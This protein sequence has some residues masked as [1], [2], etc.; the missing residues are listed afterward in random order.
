MDSL[1]LS[2]LNQ[3]DDDAWLRVADR[4]ERAVHPVDRAALRIWLHMYPLALHRAMA[5]ADDPAALA[6]R[7]VLKG[8]WRLA[9]QIDT[10]HRFFY[11]HRYWPEVRQAAIAYV[12]RGSA[13][14]SL[15]LGA[16]IQELAREAAA[17]LRVDASLLTGIAAVSLRTI[18]Q[19]GLDAVRASEGTV[20]VADRWRRL[21]A[22]EVVRQREADD[23]QGLF[24][25]LRKQKR[26]T[27]TFAEGDAAAS[28]PLLNSQ[29]ITTAAA[30]DRRDYRAQDPRCSEG[31]IP[32]HCRSCS[33][34]TCWVGVL[35]GAR[36]LG[37]ME[38]Q[39]R[40]KLA[41]LGYIDTRETHPVIRLACMAQA[42]GAVSIVIPPWNAQLGRLLKTPSATASPRRD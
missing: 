5:A 32:V 2:F 1:F 9:D 6:R 19:T 31:P 15:D 12:T 41:E 24:G 22:D 38:D 11:G 40:A 21:S 33:C 29:H 27:V 28:F 16:Q 7:L 25:F 8:D 37:A 18:Q 36:K 10:S 3:H 14:G 35:G 20:S 39:E 4:V 13:P 17:P 30:L 42:F 26:W 23:W 34:G